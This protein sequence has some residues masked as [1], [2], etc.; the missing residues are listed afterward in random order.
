[1]YIV[2]WS[3]GSVSWRCGCVLRHGLQ[4]CFAASVLCCFSLNDRDWR[5]RYTRFSVDTRITFSSPDKVGEISLTH[6]DWKAILLDSLA[7]N[8]Q[9]YP[10]PMSGLVNGRVTMFSIHSVLSH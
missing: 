7:R 5:G 4:Y 1:M 9:L 3:I 10:H 6:Q 8:Q 2:Q